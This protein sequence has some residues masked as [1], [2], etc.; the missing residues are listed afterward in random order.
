MPRWDSSYVGVSCAFIYNA[1]P[2]AGPTVSVALDPCDEPQQG[3]MNT[4]IFIRL[5]FRSNVILSLCC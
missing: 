2:H 3:F 4:A 1:R 5:F